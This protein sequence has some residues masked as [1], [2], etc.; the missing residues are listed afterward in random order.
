MYAERQATACVAG[1]ARNFQQK[2]H[3]QHWC[4]AKWRDAVVGVY[5]GI[6]HTLRIQFSQP[7]RDQIPLAVV[8]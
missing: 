4:E 6:Y 1:D 7:L 2:L 3:L 5:S 8:Q